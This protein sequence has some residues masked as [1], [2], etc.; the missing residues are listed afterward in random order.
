MRWMQHVSNGSTLPDNDWHTV[1]VQWIY[2]R[3]TGR[4][5]A[6]DLLVT[7]AQNKIMHEG[8]TVST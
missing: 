8:L 6:A 1:Y 5:E 4:P 2:L 7:M 3:S